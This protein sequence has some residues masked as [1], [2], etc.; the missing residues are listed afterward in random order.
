MADF[1]AG[2]NYADCPKIIMPG[3]DNIGSVPFYAMDGALD[4]MG[5]DTELIGQIYGKDIKLSNTEFPS[6]TPSTTAKIIVTTEN[7][8][9]V[10]AANMNDYAYTV[11][12]LSDINIVYDG[13]EDNKAMVTRVCG[14]QWQSLHRRPYGI[15]NFPSMNHSYNYCATESSGSYYVFYRNTSGTETWTTGISYGFYT[16]LSAATFSSTSSTTPNVTLKAPTVSAR[17]STT[18]LKSANMSRVVAASS[19]IKIR[20]V[21]YRSPATFSPIRNYYDRALEIYNNPIPAIST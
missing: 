17:V 16:T 7:V 19:I 14:A 8:T 10:Y 21:L 11:V 9:P 6:W 3:E 18:Y 5:P 15:A 1:Y 13:T 4:W 2:Q 12:W 20:G